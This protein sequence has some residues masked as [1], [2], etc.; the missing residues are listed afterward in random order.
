MLVL[1]DNGHGY[2]T[3]GKCSPDKSLEEWH[4]TREIASRVGAYL[5]SRGVDVRMVTPEVNDVSLKERCERVNRWCREVNGDAILVSIHVNAAGADGKWHSAGGWCAYTSL[6][7]TKADKLAECLYD[8]AEER[9]KDYAAAMEN[10]KAQGN[11]D[12]KQKAIR[13]D[14]TDGDSDIEAGLYILK[15]SSCPAV[16]T[17]NLFMDNHTDCNYLLSEYGME[18]IA[19]IHANGIV[20]YINSIK[21]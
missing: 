12:K 13:R 19:E 7:E 14:R 6:G 4:Y 1:I 8:E 10:L 2:D 9:L 3:A 18:A 17:E 11:Y 5:Q 21:G 15:H 16:L 20:R